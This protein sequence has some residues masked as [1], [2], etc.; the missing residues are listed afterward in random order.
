MSHPSMLRWDEAARRTTNACSSVLDALLNGENQYQELL[1]D[2]Q[3]S[4][5]TDQSFAD[6]LFDTTAT[7]DQ[8]AQVAD[9]RQALVSVHELYQAM[10]NVSVAQADRATDIRRLT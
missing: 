4:G 2:Y 5:G 3:W 10:D 1:V 7:P 8:V 9:L 6:L